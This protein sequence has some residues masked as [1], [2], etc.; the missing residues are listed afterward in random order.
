MLAISPPNCLSGPL[1]RYTTPCSLSSRFLDC[2]GRSLWGLRLPRGLCSNP[3]IFFKML[4]GIRLHGK[5]VLRRH[6]FSPSPWHILSMVTTVSMA[7]TVSSSRGAEG[8]MKMLSHPQVR[9]HT[10]LLSL[11]S[12]QIQPT[13]Y[14]NL[15]TFSSESAKWSKANFKIK[16]AFLS[17]MWGDE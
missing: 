12:A 11:L 5:L 8:F 9:T 13:I 1:A 4:E 16:P 3:V 17:N 15:G 10:C 14:V 7:R 2:F 6:F